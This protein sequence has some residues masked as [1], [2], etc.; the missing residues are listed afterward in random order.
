MIKLKKPL[1]FFDLE[2]TGVN[3][4][5]DRIIEM[6]LFKIHPNGNEISKT[7]RVN[8]EIE[9]PESSTE[10]HGI[11]NDDVKDCPTF[12]MIAKDIVNII[13]DAD[14]GGYNSNKFDIP[15][16]AEEFLRANIEFDLKKRNFID[17]MVIFMKKEPRNLTAA[18]KFYCNKE[19]ECAHSAKAD[20]IATYEIFKSQIEKY[21]DLGD[22][23]E[24]ISEFSSY[25]KNADFAGRLIYD[26]N[27]IVIINFGKHKG[28]ALEDV[29]KKDPAYYSWVQKGDFPLYT[30]KIF[31]E[32]YLKISNK[33]NQS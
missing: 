6:S 32:T 22:T 24:T 19:L 5:S 25:N 8:P 11:T 31:T 9:I 12:K 29:L 10:I 23:I 30:K 1:I 28:K 33:I 17:I 16:L 3:P 7:F 21:D 4:S 18:Y 14:I 15:L 2:T 27:N 20:T 26:D 13:E